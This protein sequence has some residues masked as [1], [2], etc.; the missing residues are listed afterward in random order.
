[1]PTPDAVEPPEDRGRRVL[2]AAGWPAD[3]PLVPPPPMQPGMPPPS[4]ADPTAGGY[5]C[6]AIRS[7]GQLVQDREAGI[8]EPW[9]WCRMRAGRGTDHP[10]IGR[11]RDHAG[12]T[13]NGR[14]AARLRLSE[15]VQP[16]MA[17]LARALT[18]PNVPWS[19]KQRSADSLLDRA[20]YP[21]RIDVDVDAQRDGLT[22]RLWA[23]LE[24]QQATEDPDEEG[25][26]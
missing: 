4:L 24:E 13:P 8:E 3:V 19:V 5:Y 18:D 7:R 11:C 1:M 25:E 14:A 17:T 10:R 22:E 12:S 16:A 20:G 2:V 21:R 6:G 9:P 15:L 23:L 26:D